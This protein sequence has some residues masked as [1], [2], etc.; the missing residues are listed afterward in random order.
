MTYQEHLDRM[1]SA[2][3]VSA[4]KAL[5]YLDVVQIPHIEALLDKNPG[6]IKKWRE[7]GVCPWFT[8]IT[9]KV[10]TRSALTYQTTPKRSVYVGDSIN[11]QATEV[12]NDLTAEL[13]F[14]LPSFDMEARLLKTAII[15]AQAVVTDSGEKILF[16]VLTQANCD[17]DY[18]HKTGQI[19]SLMYES[20]G[21]SARGNK[22]YHYWDAE[23]VVDIEVDENGALAVVGG[24]SHG[25]G[26]IPAAILFDTSQPTSGFWPREAWDELIRLNE[27]VNLFH[28]ELRFSQRFQAFPPLF[29]N[30]ELPDDIV[31]GAD[32]VV[33]FKSDISGAAPY[34]EYKT[35]PALSVNLKT[36]QDWISS[37]AA[38]VAENWGVNLT[39]GGGGS[40]DSGFKLVVEEIWNLETRKT[41]QRYA[42]KFELQLFEVIKAI[43]DARGY[44]IP[45]DSWIEVDFKEPS[46][47]VNELEK[48]QIA[49]EQI[50]LKVMSIE[51]Y[52]RRENPDITPAQI[53][54]RKAE[55]NGNEI[56]DFTQELTG[57]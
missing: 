53:A 41:R 40:A 54:E 39:I 25:Y 6:G 35:P 44:G 21:T 47:P 52:W 31:V 9:Q 20:A 33:N 37:L 55:I 8:N 51:E 10:I 2:A 14:I 57:E 18:D 30:V 45:S 27:G 48:W 28:T 23:S 36:F 49:K 16:S 7:R 42:S 4:A 24:D 26:I 50:G 32:A 46:L 19:R 38:D 22:L 15:L 29:T 11:D 5:D 17:V 13:E 56:P 12:Y 3:V 43:S 1:K 34:L